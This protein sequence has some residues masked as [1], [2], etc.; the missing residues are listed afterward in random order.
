MYLIV[1]PNLKKAYEK[2]LLKILDLSEKIDRVLLPLP[3]DANEELLMYLLGEIPIE[4][5]VESLATRL[6]SKTRAEL[7]TPL[8]RGLRIVASTLP[9][10][11][12]VCYLPQEVVVEY[13]TIHSKII[14]LLYRTR[15][16]GHVDVSMWRNILADLE[17]RAKVLNG[18]LANR[19]YYYLKGT[20][21]VIASS[22]S[23]VEWLRKWGVEV[24]VVP[25]LEDYISNPLEV[26]LDTRV[27]EVD[28]IILEKLVKDAVDY[29]FKYVLYASDLD[30]AYI[31]WRS[32][33]ESKRR[34]S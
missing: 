8:L 2:A 6:R 23:M 26:L 17:D 7:I 31:R 1:V 19:V 12:V 22:E 21:T 11:E 14:A 13:A 5:L 4:Q 33:L 18:I 34:Q 29:I 10:V 24:E 20:T 15:I 28:D 9:H 27:Q 32:Y 25:V 3:E 16:S 30:E